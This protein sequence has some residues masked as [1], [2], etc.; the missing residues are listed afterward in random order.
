M[1]RRP[2]ASSDQEAISLNFSGYYARKEKEEGGIFICRI[3]QRVV[4]VVEREKKKL[5]VQNW[6]LKKKYRVIEV[7]FIT[8]AGAVRDMQSYL[9]L[10]PIVVQH[11][12]W[13]SVPPTSKN[14]GI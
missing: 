7:L 12:H 13:H 4:V 3:E 1:R 2:R 8:L 10:L 14:M 11:L 6:G 9:Y 5:E